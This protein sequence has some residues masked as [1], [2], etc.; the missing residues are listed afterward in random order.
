MTR[1]VLLVLKAMYSCLLDFYYAE[2]NS[3]EYSSSFRKKSRLSSE[4]L[5]SC[6]DEKWIHFQE[7]I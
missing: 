4:K 6:S 1:P 3:A 7:S 2:Q 5:C